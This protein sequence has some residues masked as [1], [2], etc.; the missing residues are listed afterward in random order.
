[1][2]CEETHE[3]LHLLLDGELGLIRRR[4]VVRHLND[5]SPCAEEASFEFD[6]RQVV[7]RKCAEEAPEALRERILQN[8]GIQH[9]PITGPSAGELFQQGSIA[10]TPIDEITPF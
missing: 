9:Q 2:D 4:S 10:N 3:H 5:C 1:M 7:A 8:L 6:F